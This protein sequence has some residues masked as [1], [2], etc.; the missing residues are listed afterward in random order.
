V[1]VTFELLNAAGAFLL[2]F[3]TVAFAVAQYPEGMAHNQEGSEE[4]AVPL[5]VIELHAGVD[6]VH[7]VLLEVNPEGRETATQ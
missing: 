6:L 5:G 7:V 3:G 2:L 1:E 4:L